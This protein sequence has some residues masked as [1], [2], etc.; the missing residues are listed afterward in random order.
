MA[1]AAAGWVARGAV[2]PRVPLASSFSSRTANTKGRTA[3]RRTLLRECHALQYS[4]EQNG[5]AADVWGPRHDNY[6]H[7]PDFESYDLLLCAENYG[8]E[9]LPDLSAVGAVEAPLDN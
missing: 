2:C 8:L 1:P 9:W 5:I 4:F 6:A 7:R 3:G